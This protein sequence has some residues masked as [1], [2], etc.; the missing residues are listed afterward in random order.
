MQVFAQ[1]AP[2]AGGA[3]IGQVVI[4]TVMVSGI[5]GAIA[6]LL[7]R[8]RAGRSTVLARL[9]DR[10]GQLVGLPH[11]VALPSLVLVASLLSAVFG[12]YWDVSIHIDDGRDDGPLANLAHY[13]ILFG[14]IGCLA[15]GWLAIALPRPGERPGPAAVRL[16]DGW[17][18]PVGG[19]VIATSALFG[20][21]G[22][23][24]DD[25]WHRV[26][27]QD[28]T[29]WGPT[30]LMMIGGA[31]TTLVGQALLLAEGVR[32]TGSAGG[33]DPSTAASG[34]NAPAG[35]SDPTTAAIGPNAPASGGQT[36]SQTPSQTPRVAAIAWWVRR[37]ALGGGL[38]IA[39]DVFAMEFDFGV[40]QFAAVF[41]PLLLAFGAGLGLVVAR[42]WAGAGGALAATAFYL[43]LRGILTVLVGPVLGETTPAM[44]LFVVEALCVEAVALW[45]RGR[46]PLAF[47]V[48]SG[49]AVGTIGFA[50]E[51]A[52]S[53]LVMPIPWQG[54]LMPEGLVFAVVGGL[55]G[56]TLGGLTV[57]GLR[58]E[59]PAPRI[60]R[61]AA[62][63]SLAA[64][65]LMIALGLRTTV[66]EGE[67]AIGLTET[68]SQPREAIVEARFQPPA[69][70]E[71]A[72]WA[73]VTAWQGGGLEVEP[74]EQ[75]PGG[76][77]RS[78]EPIPL[79]GEWKT[80]VRVHDGDAM[81]AAP[82]FL[83][84]DPA[85]PAKEVPATEATRSLV[86]EKEILQ[87]ELKD[88]V[89]GWAWTAGSSFVLAL[90]VG[91][92]AIVAWGIGRV[93]RSRGGPPAPAL[94][95]RR[96]RLATPTPAGAR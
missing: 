20:L 14:L 80:I 5:L 16:A 96:A 92:V 1:S 82:V 19:I 9:A 50:G 94:G 15:A 29:L 85:I 58:G 74:L 55:V 76:V 4:A 52:W 77:W 87:R 46:G 71:D 33:S 2:S 8:H 6:L 70:A 72:T 13:P 21:A 86:E 41:Q 37:I 34:P 3:A 51:W 11:W 88:D 48:A 24:L 53:Q 54:S 22:F 64:F 44:P 40:P 42:R 68:R 18:A 36:P 89:P 90:Y 30:H 47:G 35:G 79:H 7:W 75:G 60:A 69:L 17:Y 63:G 12:V 10:V 67:V 49:L 84:E 27:G 57:A 61:I 91:F 95:E 66:P 78:A 45:M 81:G 38:L 26:F 65:G 56:G 93:G 31:V 43:V 62:I 73:N 25:V 32:G 59:L 28:V 83:P 39:V 23:P